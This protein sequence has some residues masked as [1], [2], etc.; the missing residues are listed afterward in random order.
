MLFE[1][2]SE[3][4]YDAETIGVTAVQGGVDCQP[5]EVPETGRTRS[6]RRVEDNGQ[7]TTAGPVHEHAATALSATAVSRSS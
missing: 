4:W 6:V 7:V 3:A 2:I 5:T 1:E